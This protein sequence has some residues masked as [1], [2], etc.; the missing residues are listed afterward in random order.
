MPAN[1]IDRALVIP[2]RVAAPNRVLFS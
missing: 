1:L 2:A